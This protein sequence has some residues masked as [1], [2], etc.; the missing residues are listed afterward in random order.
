MCLSQ[1]EFTVTNTEQAPSSSQC[2]W[3]QA[4]A[5]KGGSELWGGSLLD[6]LLKKQV[7]QGEG[8]VP[9]KNVLLGESC[10]FPD[11]AL[12]KLILQY[13]HHRVPPLLKS[14]QTP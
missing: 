11:L 2:V 13:H 1:Q 12:A 5:T 10:S 6:R 14:P 9:I 7:F 3:E 8:T 4:D